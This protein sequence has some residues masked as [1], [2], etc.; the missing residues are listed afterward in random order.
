VGIIAHF[1]DKHGGIL[2]RRDSGADRDEALLESYPVLV[3]LEHSSNGCQSREPI[4]LQSAAR[5]ISFPFGL[6][7]PPR[8]PESRS[9]ARSCLNKIP[10]GVRPCRTSCLNLCRRCG[11]D[12]KALQRRRSP[13]FFEIFAWVE[14]MRPKQKGKNKAL[15]P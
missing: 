7:I 6:E 14:L 1:F 15:N 9:I 3:E 4:Q 10:Y 12:E 8:N 13:S 2:A 5:L 11:R